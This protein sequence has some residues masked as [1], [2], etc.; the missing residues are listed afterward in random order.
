[1]RRHCMPCAAIRPHIVRLDLTSMLK[2]AY[3][4]VLFVGSS[5]YLRQ[6]TKLSI[7]CVNQFTPF[8]GNARHEI[9][10]ELELNDEV[11]TSEISSRLEHFLSCYF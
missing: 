5:N 11:V 3:P 8:I 2:L 6:L 7:E 4:R 1:M 9:S 10:R